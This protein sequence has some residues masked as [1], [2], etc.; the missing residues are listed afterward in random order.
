[1]DAR[2]DATGR[3]C[4]RAT[5]GSAGARDAVAA[6]GRRGAGAGLGGGEL[7]VGLHG[8]CAMCALVVR[9]SRQRERARARRRAP[10][11]ASRP[12][13]PHLRSPLSALESRS[14]ASL[15]PRNRVRYFTT[16]LQVLRQAC[17]RAGGVCT[18][19]RSCGGTTTMPLAHLLSLSASS[20]TRLRSS[21]VCGS[22]MGC[23]R[24]GAMSQR[25][26]SETNDEGTKEDETRRGR[27]KGTG[28][29]E[30]RRGRT[31]LRVLVA[32]EVGR[33]VLVGGAREAEVVGRVLEER[34]VLRVDD[35]VA[36]PDRV[37]LRVG[38]VV[39]CRQSEAGK[40]S[41]RGARSTLCSTTSPPSV[42]PSPS[43]Y[44]PATVHH[45]RL[46]VERSPCP[47]PDEPRACRRRERA[48]P[49]ARGGRG[50]EGERESRDVL[51]CGSEE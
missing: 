50:R 10:G 1:V 22:A 14:H 27:R 36:R 9:A 41:A 5:G 18:R 37:L 19:A 49:R 34:L 45:D 30:T 35:A 7:V 20:W 40:G 33:P 43:S 42:A 39:D 13:R 12:A 24:K 29:G 32:D 38:L 11:H 28:R 15:D 6:A 17:E 46:A 31:H 25:G 44:W 23:E 16:A 4:A 8:G 3:P 48:D 47:A 2:L 21:S 26:S 51:R